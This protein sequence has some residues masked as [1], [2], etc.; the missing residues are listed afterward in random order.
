MIEE[1]RQR[2]LRLTHALNI[3]IVQSCK[4]AGGHITLF[5][6]H[7]SLYCEVGWVHNY[8]HL[9]L[10]DNY[11]RLSPQEKKVQWPPG[12]TST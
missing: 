1:K 6:T 4:C 7:Y 10:H 12:V 3:V 9:A 11:K 2:V 5:L 8:I